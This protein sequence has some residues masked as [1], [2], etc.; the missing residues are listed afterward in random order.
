MTF[1]CTAQESQHANNRLFAVVKPNEPLVS[2]L[3]ETWMGEQF[4]VP[5]PGPPMMVPLP[6]SS[7]DWGA[8]TPARESSA[9]GSRCEESIEY[10]MV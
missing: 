6:P 10:I 9:S 5:Q 1:T 3:R 4:D 2:N 8:P 7:D